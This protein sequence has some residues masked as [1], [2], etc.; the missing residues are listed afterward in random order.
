M[1]VFNLFQFIAYQSNDCIISQK[2]SGGELVSGER[3]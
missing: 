1:I 3:A 2:L